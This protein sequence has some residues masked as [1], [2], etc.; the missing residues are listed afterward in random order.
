MAGAGIGTEVGTNFSPKQLKAIILFAT[1]KYNC[2]QVAEQVGVSIQTI[3]TWRRNPNFM[4][5]IYKSAK[6]A[7]RDILPEI[8]K[9]ATE[10]ALKG[11]FQ[12]IKIILDH[13]DNMEANT[14]KDNMSSITFTW[15]NS[16]HIDTI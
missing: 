10:E 6:L 8:Y 3:S 16:E 15:D 13:I 14:K 11:K 12:H 9:V 4:D 1:G 7:L 2:T 5:E